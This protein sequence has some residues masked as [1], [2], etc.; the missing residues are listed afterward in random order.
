MSLRPLAPGSQ[1]RKWSNDRFSIISTTTCSMLLEPCGDSAGAALA[2]VWDN[3]SA[4]VIAAPV[5]A[6][7]SWRKLRR[8]STAIMSQSSDSGQV[9]QGRQR[10]GFGADNL[11]CGKRPLSRFSGAR[12]LRSAPW[13]QQGLRDDVRRL[14][15]AGQ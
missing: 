15:L 13:H 2:A 8:V 9:P 7:M 11:G 1:P 14:D 6:P 12:W 4:P 5:E 10:G 3:N